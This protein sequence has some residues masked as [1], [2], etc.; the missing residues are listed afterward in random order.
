MVEP[1]PKKPTVDRPVRC[2]QHRRKRARR[3]FI[4]ERGGVAA[5]VLPV[6]RGGTYS[7]VVTRHGAHFKHEALLP[8]HRRPSDFA[9]CF[10]ACRADGGAQRVAPWNH[11]LRGQVGTANATHAER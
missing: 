6:V 11:R 8:F 9:K 4:D 1:E 5:W 3:S 10:P 7:P 2:S